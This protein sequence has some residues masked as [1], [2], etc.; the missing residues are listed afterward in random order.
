MAGE[1]GV[2][3]EPLRQNRFG[4]Q[5]SDLMVDAQG[6]RLYV[7]GTAPLH[8]LVFDI[9]QTTGS[10]TEKPGSSTNRSQPGTLKTAR[11]HPGGK[12]LFLLNEASASSMSV[13]LRI[14]DGYEPVV[15]SPFVLGRDARTFAIDPTGRASSSSTS[16]RIALR[17]TR[18]MMPAACIRWPARRS[19]WQAA[20][21]AWKSIRAAAFST[22]RIRARA[23]SPSSGSIERAAH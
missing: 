4:S 21:G 12:F 3:S 14:A 2:L 13:Y 10:L 23:R 5:L 15:G 17:R 6:E 20:R 1:D 11:V 19:T 18:S 7:T 22:S 8:F 9:N 16:R